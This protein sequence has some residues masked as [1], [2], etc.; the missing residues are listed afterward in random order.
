MVYVYAMTES[1]RQIKP[2]REEMP[3]GVSIS[4]EIAVE[5]APE[6]V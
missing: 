1:S 3:Q 5:V 6:L 2:D 4:V